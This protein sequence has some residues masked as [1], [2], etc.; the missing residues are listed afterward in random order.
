MVDTIGLNDKTF[1]DN[2][3]TPHTDQ[4][5]V[6]E[7]WKLIEGGNILQATVKVEDPGAFNM[8]WT[9]VQRWK[10]IARPLEEYLCEPSNDG[11]FNYDVVP[12]PKADK[13]DF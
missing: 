12:L 3:R 4:I 7:R 10:K 11:Y 5:H 6:V 13:P 2:Y 1:V 8:P 9:G